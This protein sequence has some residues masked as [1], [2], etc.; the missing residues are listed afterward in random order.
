M[1]PTE[2]GIGNKHSP[3]GD[4]DLD[5]VEMLGGSMPLPRDRDERHFGKTSAPCSECSE[6]SPNM[7]RPDF[8]HRNLASSRVMLPSVPVPSGIGNRLEISS[9]DRRRPKFGYFFIPSPP[10]RLGIAVAPDQGEN[11]HIGSDVA[12]FTSTHESRPNRLDPGLV[13]AR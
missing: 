9:H 7:P 12:E 2:I 6:H 3:K 10:P 5:V 1:I 4:V 11:G 13:P 8:H